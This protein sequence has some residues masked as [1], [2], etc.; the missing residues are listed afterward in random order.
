MSTDISIDPE[1]FSGRSQQYDNRPSAPATTSGG[2]DSHP[3]FLPPMNANNPID[4]GLNQFTPGGA[5]NASHGERHDHDD[6]EEHGGDP[7]SVSAQQHGGDDAKRSRACDNCRTLKVRCEPADDPNDALCKRCRRT[8]KNCVTTPAS[9]KRQKKDV[10]LI[11]QLKQQV[12][13]LSAVVRAQAAQQVT[14][15][16]QESS[17]PSYPTFGSTPNFPAPSLS[18]NSSAHQTPSAQTFATPARTWSERQSQDSPQSPGHKKRRIEGNPHNGS[19][20][21]SSPPDPPSMAPGAQKPLVFDHSN[22]IKRIDEILGVAMA[23]VVFE[24]YKT[25]ITTHFPAVVL[26]PGTSAKEMREKKP[27]LFLSIVTAASFSFTKKAVSPTT[28]NELVQLFKDQCA[29][30]IWR[31]GEKSLEIVQALQVGVLWYRPPPHFEQHAFYLMANTATVMSLDLGLGKKVNAHQMK[32]NQGPFRRVVPDSGSPE[33]RRALLICYYLALS[34][35]MVM[36]RPILLRWS[37]FMDESIEMLETSP[38]A[39][40]TDRL[41]CYHVKLMKLA[42]DIATQ[43]S[44][45]DPTAAVTMQDSKVVY[46]VNGFKRHLQDLKSQR[47]KDA[48]DPLVTLSE[49]VLNLYIHEVALHT[50]QNTE[51]FRPPFMGDN[52]R[53]HEA[54]QIHGP[55][56]VEA[57]GQCLDSCH[58]ILDSFIDMTF[59]QRCTMPV[60]FCVR[61]VYSIVCLMKMWVAIN[62]PGNISSVIDQKDLKVDSYLD[63]VV[64]TFETYVANEGQAPHGKFF[65]IS[66]RLRTKFKQIKDGGARNPDGSVNFCPAGDDAPQTNPQEQN[67]SASSNS[68]PHTQNQAT[69]LRLLSE[70]AMGNSPHTQQRSSIPQ[71]QFPQQP[72]AQHGQMPGQNGWYDNQQTYT[73]FSDIT[74]DPNLDVSMIDFGSLGMINTDFSGMM[75]TGASWMYPPYNGD[76]DPNA[77]ALS[78]F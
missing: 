10:S 22:I 34:I 16:S 54:H 70:V 6:E 47:S 67:V 39:L 1:L 23:E 53:A 42:E 12:D 65:F 13:E 71:A 63:R 57:L 41:L 61:I 48:T 14:Q 28:Q 77:Q 2:N 58:G 44:M 52:L 51:D 49:H 55:A 75:T 46:A 76:M 20:A 15:A 36:R 19:S 29:D 66:K 24:R 78:G 18:Y 62:G 40:A 30:I 26:A 37:K 17:Y 7:G 74:F 11:T 35:T 60:I 69:R 72:Q 4:P 9:K 21:K 45:D 50:T 8:K 33:A 68:A 38:D 3:Y 73:D 43:F 32:M 27:L 59:A 25:D 64:D 31:N 5:S 56:H